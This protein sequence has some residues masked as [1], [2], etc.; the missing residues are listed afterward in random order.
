MIPPLEQDTR[1]KLVE[2]EKN[3]MMLLKKKKEADRTVNIKI[4]EKSAEIKA[5]KMEMKK[6]KQSKAHRT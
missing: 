6:A 4:R 3:F 5:L 1:K 2:A